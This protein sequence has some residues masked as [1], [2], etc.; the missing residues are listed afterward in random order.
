MVVAE[1]GAV[2]VVVVV[3]VVISFLR[4]RGHYIWQIHEKVFQFFSD[5]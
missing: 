1:V 5:V 3:I 4:N 2:L